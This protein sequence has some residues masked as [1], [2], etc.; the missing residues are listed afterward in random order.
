MAISFQCGRCGRSYKTADQWAG[1][2]VKCKDCGQSV[3]IPTASAAPAQSP[4]LD[5]YGLDDAGSGSPVPLTAGSQPGLAPK[6]ERVQAPSIK[7]TKSKSAKSGSESSGG[8]TAMRSVIGTMV[9]LA[10]IGFRIYN[11]Y[12]RNQARPD[13]RR[14]A[15]AAAGAQG[16]LPRAVLDSSARQRMS[17]W[18]MPVLP[19]PGPGIELEPGIRFHE[20]TIGSGAGGPDTLPGHRGKLWLYLPA[21]NH[22]PRSLPA[23]LIAGAGS[24]LITG[25][26]LG[27]GDRAEHVPYVRAGFA[28]LAYELDGAL[29]N[30]KQPSNQELFASIAAFSSAEA[31]LLNARIALEFA[32][33]RV[34]ALDPKRIFAVGHSSAATLA[35]IIAENE[36][37]AAACVAFAPAVDLAIQ[38][39]P[40]AQQQIVRALPAAAPLFT[41]LNPRSGEMKIRCPVFLF[42]ADDDARF[43]GQVRDLAER[44]SAAGK[45]VTVEHVPQG[46]HY[47]SMIHEGIPRAI[48]W[49]KNLPPSSS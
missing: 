32:T 41:Q 34:P 5:V 10:L 29:G 20:V 21:G 38:Y 37:R 28:V 2:T 25:M 7:S 47:E 33:T 4:D 36:P 13:N 30:P 35:L 18:T 42:C 17:A 1:K 6:S 22:A 45:K 26:D 43:A 16:S 15:A 46:G 8:K 49:L 12:Q 3:T 9:V 39:P 23:I 44:L 48:K 40:Q 11:R 14:G 27:D 24:N 19:D 31:G